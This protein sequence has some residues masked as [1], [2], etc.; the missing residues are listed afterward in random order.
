MKLRAAYQQIELY[1]PGRLPIDTDLSD[2]TNLFGVAPSVRAFF[3]SVP[4]SLVTRYPSVFAKTL[5]KTLSDLHGVDVA[6]ITTGCGSD[7]VIDSTM[8]AFC[9][10]GDRVA[11]PWPTFGVVSTFARM[12]A[13][14]P[15]AVT[16]GEDF[17]VDVKGIVET[18][19]AVN[20]LC[21]PNNPTGTV[22]PR[23]TI[24][25][26]DGS[27]DGLLLLDEAYADFSDA[28]YATFAVR[29]QRTVSLRTLSKVYG[30]AG[31]RV[32]YAIGPAELIHEIEKSRGPYKVGGVAEAVASRVVST[33]QAWRGGVVAETRQNRT[34][35]ANEIDTRGLGQWPSAGNFILVGL[36]AGRDAVDMNNALRAHGVAVRPFKSLPHAGEC[37]RV[38]VGPW[39]SMQKFLDA[40]DRVLATNK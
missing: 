31:F 12:N 18:R 23:A 13:A 36:P 27:L 3:E 16:S 28:D 25:E 35:L 4:D 24:E 17:S 33:D 32:G 22:V 10:P 15:V 40:L 2:N 1:E 39:P 38:T 14:Q 34:R 6:N 9:E 30:L 5:K 11:Y 21:S 20:Y 37:L 19:A 29:S 8:R 26:L 7:D